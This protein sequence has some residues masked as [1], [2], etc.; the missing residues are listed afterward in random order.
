MYKYSNSSNNFIKIDIINLTNTN[1]NYVAHLSNTSSYIFYIKKISSISSSSRKLNYFLK[2]KKCF[3]NVL[4][5]FRKYNFP[6]YSLCTDR[7]N[8]AG[9]HF[10]CDSIRD[11]VNI[12]CKQNFVC[13]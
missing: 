3:H 10:M 9:S 13:N 4:L 7:F 6:G 11:Q 2:K 1:L 5:S 8:C 12:F